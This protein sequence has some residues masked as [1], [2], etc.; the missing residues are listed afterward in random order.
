MGPS[1]N[2]S[3]PTV[4]VS[5]DFPRWRLGTLRWS[6]S[7]S[8]VASDCNGRSTHGFRY[9]VVRVD[10]VGR[11]R[12][13]AF[14]PMTLMEAQADPH[15]RRPRNTFSIVSGYDFYSASPG[16]GRRKLVPQWLRCAQLTV[17]LANGVLS[18]FESQN[19]ALL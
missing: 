3:T 14:T 15:G 1:Q 16:D 10:E 18:G 12:S 8:V 19:I 11:G 17:G 5:D 4:T 6:F 7:L 13:S 9:I 2:R